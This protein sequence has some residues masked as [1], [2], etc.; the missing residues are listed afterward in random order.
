MSYPFDCPR[1][2]C[3]KEFRTKIGGF[4][5]V[6]SHFFVRHGRF[7]FRVGFPLSDAEPPSF[8]ERDD[9]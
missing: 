3:E 6:T 8:E 5:G 7:S 1:C 4:L 2:E 9:G